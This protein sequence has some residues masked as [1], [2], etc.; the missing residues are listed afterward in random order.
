MLSKVTLGLILLFLY[1]FNNSSFAQKVSYENG[2][3]VIE[4]RKGLPVVKTD[5][6][7][8]ELYDKEGRLLYKFPINHFTEKI[9]LFRNKLYIIENERELTIHIY[10]ISDL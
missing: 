1:G 7:E 6:Y 8:I 10:R 5:M 4:N 9:R 2:V 3:K